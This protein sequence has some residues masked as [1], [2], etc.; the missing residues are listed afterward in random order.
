MPA[1]SS[2]LSAVMNASRPAKM[3]GCRV[4]LEVELAEADEPHE[5]ARVD[6]SQVVAIQGQGGEGRELGEGVRLQ[7]H[8]NVVVQIELCKARESAEGARRK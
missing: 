5:R 2:A 3:Q 1:E 7:G 8:Q 4:R 6:L